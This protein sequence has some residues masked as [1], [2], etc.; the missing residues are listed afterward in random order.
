MLILERLVEVTKGAFEGK[1]REKREKS[2][3]GLF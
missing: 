1:K 3:F 2:E